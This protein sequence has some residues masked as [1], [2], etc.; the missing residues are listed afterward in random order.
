MRMDVC[1]CTILY[2]EGAYVCMYP[3]YLG[4]RYCDQ[5][6]LRATPSCMQVC[7]VLLLLY[8]HC[9]CHQRLMRIPAKEDFEVG[10]GVGR[11]LRLVIIYTMYTYMCMYVCMYIAGIILSFTKPHPKEFL[12]IGSFEKTSRNHIS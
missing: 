1:I 10:R 5:E 3:N 11:S 7:N 4:P 2:D 12:C 9:R 6:E 8:L